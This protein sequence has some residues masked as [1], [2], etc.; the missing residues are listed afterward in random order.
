MTVFLIGF[1]G[2]G[3]TTIGRKLAGRLDCDFVDL[4]AAI[5]KAEGMYIH[6]LINEKGEVYF[7]ETESH[8]LKRLGLKDKV[9]S[10]GGGTPCFFD[11]MEWMKANGKVVFID[12][13]EGVIFSR[14]KTT[15]LTKRPLLKGLDDQG[16]KDFI[17][18]K[19]AE[20]MPFYA[21][22]D[23]VFDPMA[24]SIDDLSK[25]IFQE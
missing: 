2:S 7:R 1:M 21:M 6:D 5:E 11:N 14:L 10:T 22:A 4:D 18:T 16:L 13:N 3:K 8:T 23:I 12:P 17:R 9:I 19:L 15:D 20:R 24:G 25:Q